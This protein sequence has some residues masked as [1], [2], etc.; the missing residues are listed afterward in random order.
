MPPSSCQ[1]FLDNAIAVTFFVYAHCAFRF[2][3]KV[4]VMFL[5]A[6]WILS[7]SSF[8]EGVLDGSIMSDGK[9]VEVSAGVLSKRMDLNLFEQITRQILAY[10]HENATQDLSSVQI[11][12]QGKKWAG[13]FTLLGG[14]SYIDHAGQQY[15]SPN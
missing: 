15:V 8:V 5:T 14:T 3:F 9:T 2:L 7:K 13:F 4:T 11:N 1:L 10:R 6:L 12:S